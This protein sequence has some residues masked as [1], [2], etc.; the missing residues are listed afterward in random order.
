MNNAVEQIIAISKAQLQALEG[1]TTN[2]HAGAEK[3][4]ELNLAASKAA[5][6]ESF[7]HLQAVLGAKDAPELMALQSGLTKPLTE[8]SAAYLQHVQTIATGTGADFTKAVEANMAEVQKA[9][10][11]FVDTLV[12]NVPAGTESAVAAFKSAMTLGQNAV[13]SAQTSAKKAAEVSQSSLTEVSDQAV[14]A[15][16]KTTKAT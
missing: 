16:K 8:K 2:A 10:S 14:D 13:E 9:F 5:L 7:G 15:T 3:L 11:G 4:V 1:M 12:K 6:G